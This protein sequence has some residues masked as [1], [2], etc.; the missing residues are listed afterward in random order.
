MPG[1]AQRASGSYAGCGLSLSA[2]GSGYA[3]AV[4][5]QAELDAPITVE[6]ELRG[7]TDPAI[8]LA[9]IARIVSLDYDGEAFLE[10]GERDPVIRALQRAHPGQRPVL[11]H[12]PYE[13]AAWS[14]ISARRPGVQAARLRTAISEQLGAK[15]ELA[16]ETLHAF[17]QPEWLLGL[18]DDTPG[19]NSE[20]VDR[21]RGVELAAGAASS[22]RASS[23]HRTRTRVYG[24]A[25]DQGDRAVLR[26]SR[27]VAREWI[28]RRDARGCRGEG[29]ASRRAVLRFGLAPDDRAVR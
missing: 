9:Q 13:G 28:R 20:K 29:P 11:F 22:T 7:V 3:G 14:I 25:A 8:A 6:L 16:G 15:F 2:G 10:V 18:G 12:S 27:R 19:L 26:R 1:A 23:C 21:L 17:P 5:R 4:L 24:G